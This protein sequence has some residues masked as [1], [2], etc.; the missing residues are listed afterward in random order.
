MNLI[1]R[2]NK[3]LCQSGLAILC[4]LMLSACVTNQVE[5]ESK[6][7]AQIVLCQEGRALNRVVN[8]P[9]VVSIPI[10]RDHLFCG[11]VTGAPLRAKGYHSRPDG[12]NPVTVYG[13]NTP[14]HP[15]DARYNLANFHIV[16]NGQD[17]IKAL[18][19]MFPDNCSESQVLNS[20][21]HAYN[22]SNGGV[23]PVLPNQQFDGNSSP[24]PIVVGGNYCLEGGGTFN[25]RGFTSNV[26][27][28]PN[29]V[30]VL[31][32]RSAFPN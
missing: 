19:T 1:T 13:T 24:A 9:N 4:A 15:V 32:I 27:V 22:T 11:E 3:Y 7:T 18:S 31:H 21:A 14:A 6:S 16:Q 25:I 23:P 10:D 5:T 20:I 12:V 28:N 2:K 8:A 26:V 30:A 17:R 29:G